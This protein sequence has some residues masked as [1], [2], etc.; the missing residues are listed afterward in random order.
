MS[1]TENDFY[2]SLYDP[3][4]VNEEGKQY[5]ITNDDQRKQIAIV[6][7]KKEVTK[8]VDIH[9]NGTTIIKPDHPVTETLSSVTVNTDVGNLSDITLNKNISVYKNNSSETITPQLGKRY[10]KVILNYKPLLCYETTLLSNPLYIVSPQELEISGKYLL[11]QN[12]KEASTIVTQEMI[13]QNTCFVCTTSDTIKILP[14]LSELIFFYDETDYNSRPMVCIVRNT[15]NEEIYTPI[16]RVFALAIDHCLNYHPSDQTAFTKCFCVTLGGFWK[17]G[18]SSN[19][20]PKIFTLYGAT[21]G[22]N[23]NEVMISEYYDQT[24]SSYNE[25]YVFYSYAYASP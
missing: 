14:N 3:V 8:T 24:I 23:M 12:I 17:G 25:E 11:V 2:P 20:I 7:N 4:F 21:L 1:Y 16:E 5:Y 18:N 9:Q 10:N 19:N 15:S 6:G 22:Y 13:Q